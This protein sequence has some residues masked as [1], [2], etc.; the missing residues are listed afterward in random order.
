MM[1]NPITETFAPLRDSKAKWGVLI[2]PEGGFS[3]VENELITKT[4]N[5]S[6]SIVW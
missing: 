4:K 6:S 3:D 5:G 1:V 2:G